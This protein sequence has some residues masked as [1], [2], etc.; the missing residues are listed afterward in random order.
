MIS[1]FLLL[2]VFAV[3]AQEATV[4]EASKIEFENKLYNFGEIAPGPCLYF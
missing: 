2:A 3:N 1:M 4:S